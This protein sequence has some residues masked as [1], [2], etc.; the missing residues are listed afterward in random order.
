MCGR[1]TSKLLRRSQA[2]TH[3][4]RK[5]VRDEELADSTS[6]A[7]GTGCPYGAVPSTRARWC[8]AMRWQ[9]ECTA[10]GNALSVPLMMCV[11]MSIASMVHW[12]GWS[13]R[14]KF[15]GGGGDGMLEAAQE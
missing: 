15:S 12:E 3:V 2:R 11:R 7:D 4:K 6:Q 9:L 13:R 5:A 8:A 1:S 10:C 14:G